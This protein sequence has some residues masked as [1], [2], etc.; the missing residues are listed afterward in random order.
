[1]IISPDIC[2]QYSDKEI[3]M[4]SLENIDFFSCLY[5]RYEMKLKLY[6][7]RI[8]KVSDEEAEDILQ[9]VFIKVWKNLHVFDAELKLS[10]WL[11]RVVHNE[12][13]SR[14]RKNVWVRSHPTISL[15]E[16]MLQNL[17]DEMDINN[18]NEEVINQAL[19]KIEE[20]YR[21]VLILKYFEA[22]SYEE[23]SDILKIPEG[24]VATRL[25]RAKRAL[26]SK[27]DHIIQMC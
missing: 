12:V 27:T 25:S 19:S 11:Y 8:S 18:P 16:E 14:W 9:E 17:T 3:I 6:M 23:I 22:M 20:K 24:T 10:S 15:S 21:A 26:K 2:S 1:M 13:V 5:E 7:H 4:K